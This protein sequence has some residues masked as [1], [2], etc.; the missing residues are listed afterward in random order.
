MVILS[1]K[2]LPIIPQMSVGEV[3][4]LEPER[5]R[6]VLSDTNTMSTSAGSYSSLEDIQVRLKKLFSSFIR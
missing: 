3:L 6:N 4:C 2:P 1:S 5:K